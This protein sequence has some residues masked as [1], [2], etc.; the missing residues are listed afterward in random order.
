MKTAV[1][2]IMFAATAVLAPTAQAYEQRGGSLT[3][4][5]H[6]QY[7]IIEGSARYGEDFQWGPGYGVRLRYALSRQAALG[8]VFERMTFD[9]EIDTIPEPG[10]LAPP[11]RVILIVTGGEYIRHFDRRGKVGKSVVAGIGFYHPTIEISRN[12]AEVA[13]QEDNF[14]AWV[15]GALEYFPRRTIGVEFGLRLYGMLADGGNSGV[16]EGSVGVNFYLLK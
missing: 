14:L 12:E 9:S 16:A 6:G 5:F 8:L 2:V 15:G 11:Q 3:I 7:G 1:A 13:G 10:Q 4:G